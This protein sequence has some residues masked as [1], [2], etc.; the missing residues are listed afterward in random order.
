MQV[1]YYQL[2]KDMKSKFNFRYHLV[3]FA[4]THS[5]SQAAR[6]FSVTRKI[7]RKWLR[8]FEKGG[9]RALEDQ[10]KAPYHIPHKLKELDEN[11]IQLTREKYPQW[12][13]KRLKALARLPYG[14]SAIYRVLKERE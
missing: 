9:L 6:E 7:V 14:T 8:R 11:R 2:I 4:L 13:P 3:Q 5:L 12:G 1:P 10:S